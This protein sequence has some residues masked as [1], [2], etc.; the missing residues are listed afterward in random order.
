MPRLQ[1]LAGILCAAGLLAAG[2]TPVT[3]PAESHADCGGNYTD[4]FGELLSPQWP[5]DYGNNASC[6]YRIIAQ[7]GHSLSLSVNA[8]SM[9]DIGD[10]LTIHDGANASSPVIGSYSGH[11]LGAGDVINSTGSQLYLSFSSDAVNGTGGFNI[12][13]RDLFHCEEV[14]IPLCQ[15]LNYTSAIFPNNLNQNQVDAGLE[16][17]QYSPLVQLQCYG[18][19][20]QF[21]CYM[22]APPCEGGESARLP[23]RGLCEAAKSGCGPLMERFGFQWPGNLNCSHLPSENNQTCLGHELLSAPVPGGHSTAEPLGAQPTPATVCP[24]PGS[25]DYGSRVGGDFLTG[26]TVQ[27]SCDDGYTLHGNS[28]LTCADGSWDAPLPTCRAE[29]GGSITNA[30]TGVILSP[31]YPDR[32]AGNLSCTWS[33]S[34][35]DGMSLRLTFNNFSM[36]D[37]KD[38]LYVY[39]ESR[40]GDQPE[41]SLTG[42]TIPAS[43]LSWTHNITLQLV[44]NTDTGMGGFSLLYESVPETFCRD[45]GPILH[46]VS[47]SIKV[48][49]SAGQSVSYR[50]DAGYQLIG[51][52]TLTC[53]QGRQRIWDAAPPVCYAPCGGNLTSGNGTIVSPTPDP[54]NAVSRDCYWRVH[55]DD[56]FRVM[57][58]F[59][60]FELQESDTYLAIFD[61]EDPT[62]APLANFSST[63]PASADVYST[64]SQVLLLFHHGPTNS[65]GNFSLTY[66]EAQKKHC[67]DPGTVDNGRRYGDDFSI[68]SSVNYTCEDAYDLEGRETIICKPGNPPTWDYPKPRCVLV[69]DCVDPGTPENGQRDSNDTSVGASVSYSCQ[70]GYQL[71]GETTLTCRS[72]PGFRPRWDHQSPVCEEV[73]IQLCHDPAFLHYGTYTPKT[74]HYFVGS[75]V[76]FSCNSGYVLKGNKTLVCLMGDSRVATPR[77]SNAY[78]TCEKAQVKTSSARSGS[79]AALGVSLFVVLA[80]LGVGGVVA[81][82]WRRKILELLQKSKTTNIPPSFDNPMYEVPANNTDDGPSIEQSAEA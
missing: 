2:Q 62:A 19:L 28:S 53:Q 60:S 26:S 80:L 77:W 56:S 74:H 47:T 72:R 36:E 50:C 1:F 7:P 70:Q 17:S 21:L 9:A 63:A 25:P 15:T 30:S 48:L 51:N 35:P 71:V 64:D 22:Y 13:Y 34:A 38:F 58:M 82:K 14:T 5:Q 81:Y 61:G 18:Y 20:R 23:C 43:W 42:S 73:P 41:R 67:P 33:L 29:C 16:I 37:G 57:V 11:M 75:V 44:T 12:T 31:G 4:S 54:D 10:T 27:F 46:G 45:P 76:T 79:N 65:Y 6:V 39:D 69:K 3:P 59:N 78:P 66:F 32:Y 24:D 55:V 68:R 40:L 8:F 49:Y 52:A